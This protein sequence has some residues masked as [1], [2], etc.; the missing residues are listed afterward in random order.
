MYCYSSSIQSWQ[1]YQSGHQGPFPLA[2]QNQIKRTMTPKISDFK[3]IPSKLIVNFVF[4]AKNSILYLHSMWKHHWTYSHTKQTTLVQ[5]IKTCSHGTTV[6][7]IAIDVSNRLHCFV[8]R[9]S[10]VAKTTTTSSQNGLVAR[11]STFTWE[12]VLSLLMS[13]CVNGPLMCRC[14]LSYWPPKSFC[15]FQTGSVGKDW[16]KFHFT[17]LEGNW[18]FQDNLSGRLCQIWQIQIWPLT[19][20]FC[21]YLV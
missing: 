5:R 4:I 19:L 1:C 6:T 2:K 16:N 20:C 17:S 9:H 10:H 21:R 13:C 14:F 15:V 12:T 3:E 8:W 18:V 7:V 11:I